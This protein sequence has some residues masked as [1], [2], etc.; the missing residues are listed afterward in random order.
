MTRQDDLFERTPP[1][2][3]TC[4]HARHEGTPC[5]FGGC[6]CDASGN[7]R[8]IARLGGEGILEHGDLHALTEAS[9]AI[10]R[11][12]LDGYW[13]TATEIVNISGQREGLRRMRELR[14][15]YIVERRRGDGTT[16]SSREFEYRLR[17]RA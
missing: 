11:M 1:T 14:R 13:H 4:R 7:A 17:R 9:R 12:M 3:A 5:P 10:E 16:H 6:T 8:V 15:S 2:C